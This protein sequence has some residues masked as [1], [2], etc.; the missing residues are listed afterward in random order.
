LNFTNINDG[1]DC[2][3]LEGTVENITDTFSRLIRDAEVEVFD[4]TSRSEK[5]HPAISEK[6][7]D[8]CLNRAISIHLYND[9]SKDY[10]IESYKT[11]KKFAPKYK[12]HCFVFKFLK[13]AGKMK[14]TGKIFHYSFFKSDA[15][16]NSML[17]EV[18]KISLI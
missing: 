5:G 12:K 4:F 9:E 1:I 13:D 15:F 3:C 18:E 14:K 17:I 6:C 10:L 8:I 7:N 16:K 11:F 2:D